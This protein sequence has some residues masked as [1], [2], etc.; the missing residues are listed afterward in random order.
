MIGNSSYTRRRTLE[1]FQKV[2]SMSSPLNPN[3][4]HPWRLPQKLDA[5]LHQEDCPFEAQAP[6]ERAP[7][8]CTT[9]CLGRLSPFPSS[10]LPS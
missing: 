9:F 2:P 7:P 1:R 8:S 4:L 3:N 10:L 6:L 5:F